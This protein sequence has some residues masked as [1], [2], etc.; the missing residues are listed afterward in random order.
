[1]PTKAEKKEKEV[2]LRATI[3][4]ADQGLKEARHER[5]K[6]DKDWD[7][8]LDWLRGEQKQKNR[9]DKQANTVTNFLFSELETIIP[10][11]TGS[12]PFAV[13]RPEVD[14]GRYAER[15]VEIA[16][17]ISRLINRTLVRNDICEHL[18]GVTFDGYYAGKG[19]L[20]C[21]WDDEA[22]GGYGDVKI[23]NPDVRNM[24]QEAG[25]SNVRDMNLIYEVTAVDRL[26]LAREHPELFDKIMEMFTTT[27]GPEQ[28]A[29]SERLQQ[30]LVAIVPTAAGAGASTNTVRFFEVMQQQEAGERKTIPLVEAWFYDDVLMETQVEIIDADSGSPI[31]DRRTG[32]P[33]TEGAFKKRYPDGRLLQYIEGT[34]L[35]FRDNKNHFPGLPYFEFCNYYFSGL[36]YGMSDLQ[37]AAPAQE[38]YN[39]RKNQIYDWMNRHMHPQK[40]YDHRAN[41]ARSRMTNEVGAWIQVGDIT[42]VREL[43]PHPPPA[44]AFESLQIE[45]ENLETLVGVHEVT[46]GLAPGQIESAAG[47]ELLQEAGD[48]RMKRKSQSIEAMIKELS[49]FLIN[50]YARF[51]KSGIHYDE[52]FAS[53]KGSDEPGIDNVGSHEFEIEISAGVNRPRSRIALQQE[54]Q[55]MLI[56]KVIDPEAYIENTEIQNKEQIIARMK[57][58]WN[59]ERKLALSSLEGPPGGNDVLTL[60]GGR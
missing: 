29:K 5:G 46:R 35:V 15:W 30:E 16:K 19:W 42:A 12:C 52:K 26:S 53:K 41:I 24:F 36:P 21:V 8:Y 20:K 6:V 1:M 13:L 45:K 57:P 32:K 54:R 43:V 17:E 55:W 27:G 59:A 37:Q 47:V 10:N 4:A 51:Y 49:R 44:A 25:K 60:G 9:S 18:V 39:I 33:K 56:N 2:E 31:L 34:N 40:L 22:Y 11:L 38:Q 3:R 28:K 7:K 50:M 23:I 48:T 14:F 58:F